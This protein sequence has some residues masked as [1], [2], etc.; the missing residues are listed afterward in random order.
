MNRQQATPPPGRDPAGAKISYWEHG[1]SGKT[2]VLVF[3]LN[4]DIALF[5]PLVEQLCQEYRIVTIEP[6]GSGDSDPLPR[7]YSFGEQAEDV[8]AVIEALDAG[9]VTAVGMSLGGN[10]LIRIARDFPAL[11]SELVL[12]GCLPDDG[13]EGTA[14]SRP[15]LLSK[16]FN[17]ALGRG[18]YAQAVSV[19]VYSVISEPETRDLAEVY[20]E[21]CLRLPRDTFLA[22]FD[23]D[24][25]RDVRPLLS[26]IKVPTLVTHGT[27]DRSVPFQAAQYIAERIPGAQLYPFEGR[28]HLPIFT[29]TKEFCEVL[30]HFLRTGTAPQQAAGD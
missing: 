2:I 23:D 13:R 22:L 8:R 21:S 10:L 19:F 5:Q 25:E 7:P 9:P 11:F 20:I 29:A 12:V 18:E 4:Y 15:E 17:E 14:I 28:G 27:S 3:P 30:R 26:E 16:E 6:R 1:S 24:A